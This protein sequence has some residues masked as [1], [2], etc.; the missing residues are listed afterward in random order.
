LAFGFQA[1]WGVIRSRPIFIALIR[2]VNAAVGLVITAAY[3]LWEIGY[4]TPSQ[5]ERNKI[6]RRAMVGGHLLFY[7]HGYGMVWSGD[8]CGDFGMRYIRPMLVR[9]GQA[10]VG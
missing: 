2:G 3:R 6:R 10:M 8:M 7:I 9:R 4:L 5:G 1:L